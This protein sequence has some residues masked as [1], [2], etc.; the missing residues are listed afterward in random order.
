MS[1]LIDFIS[2]LF[3]LLNMAIFVRVLMSWINVSQYSTFVSIIYQITDPI[4]EPL[5]RVIPPIG[6]MDI[7]PIVAMI[8]L[9]IVRRILLTGL[10]AL[11]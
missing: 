2:I 9:D 11:G 1:L 8:L 10:L 7:T 6:M 3:W 5:K 4:L